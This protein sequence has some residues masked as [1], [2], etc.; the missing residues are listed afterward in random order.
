MCE[1]RDKN[2]VD[3]HLLPL[4]IALNQDLTW[5]LKCLLEVPTPDWLSATWRRRKNTQRRGSQQGRKLPVYPYGDTTFTFSQHK[6]SAPP[7]HQFVYKQSLCETHYSRHHMS[8]KRREQ[9]TQKFQT[10]WEPSS[11]MHIHNHYKST[12]W[13]F[14]KQVMSRKKMEI[15][16]NPKL[17]KQWWRKIPDGVGNGWEDARNAYGEQPQRLNL[18]YRGDNYTRVSFRVRKGND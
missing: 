9:V 14:I 13:P 4:L 17:L 2:T 3:S 1:Y 12:F 11:S 5:A 15:K 6:Q 7:P 18:F 10:L 16:T 8:L